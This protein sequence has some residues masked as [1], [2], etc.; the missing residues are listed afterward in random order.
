MKTAL[1]FGSFNPVHN[2]HLAIANYM[3]EYSDL[4]EVWF[5]VSPHNPFKKRKS[6]LP[7]YQRL[8]L[9]HRAIGDNYR[10]RASNIEFNLPQPNYTV[11]TLAYLREK[12][13]NKEF[14]LIMGA[15]NL[16]S[17][18]KWKNAEIILNNYEIMVYPRPNVEIIQ[19]PA[20][21]I[22]VID[23]P[24]MEISASFIRQGIAAGKD[25]RFF[26]PQA[27]YAYMREMHFYE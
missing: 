8:E 23:A 10:Y 17:L 14:V 22:T 19:P 6:L 5:V 12:Y 21:K 15:D 11:H 3:L 2:G 7:D 27:A 13:P 1:Y 18:P 9:L 16:R 26:M 25:L 4:Q 24:L 20:K